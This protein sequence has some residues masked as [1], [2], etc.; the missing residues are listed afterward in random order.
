[1]PLL[2]KLLILFLVIGFTFSTCFVILQ[3][4]MY[5]MLAEMM[6]PVPII[7]EIFAFRT[8]EW[9]FGVPQPGGNEKEPGG[10]VPATWLGPIWEGSDTPKG[11]PIGDCSGCLYLSQGYGP[12]HYALDFSC[13]AGTPI[14]NSLPGTV[15]YAGWSSVGYGNLVIVQANTPAGVIQVYYAHLRTVDVTPGMVISRGQQVG[16]VGSTG[17]STGPH[18]HYA[19]Y[20]D[21]KPINPMLTIPAGSPPFACGE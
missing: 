4:V 16:E 12:G 19:I 21:G 9:I 18:L 2:R 1:M 14:V 7:G 20:V 15:V 5:G 6:R 3:A 17:Q 13:Y 10:Q 11:W 8:W